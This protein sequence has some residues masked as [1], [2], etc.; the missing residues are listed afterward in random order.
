[1]AGHRGW[2]GRWRRSAHWL[3]RCGCSCAGSGRAALSGLGGGPV[4][5]GPTMVVD[6]L[7]PGRKTATTQHDVESTAA[8]P[9]AELKLLPSPAQQ[10]AALADG[11]RRAAPRRAVRR[12]ERARGCTTW[13]SRRRPPAHAAPDDVTQRP[14]DQHADDQRPQL[15]ERHHPRLPVRRLN[16]NN[17]MAAV[18]TRKLRAGSTRTP[19]DALW[20]DD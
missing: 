5:K 15:R 6:E 8:A 2:V 11:P 12:C 3:V 4:Q 13:G 10:L 16:L 1:M 7:D 19:V 17:V 14:E 9:F 20:H 18:E